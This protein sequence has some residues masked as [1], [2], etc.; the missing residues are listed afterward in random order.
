MNEIN[1]VARHL[2]LYQK[3]LLEF[4]QQNTTDFWWDRARCHFKRHDNLVEIT[5]VED[6]ENVTS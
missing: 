6:I 4:F 3:Y 2:H 5:K 1:N